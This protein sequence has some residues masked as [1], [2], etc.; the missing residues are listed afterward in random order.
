M[1]VDHADLWDDPFGRKKDGL[2]LI[3]RRANQQAGLYKRLDKYKNNPD[4]LNQ[5]LDEIGYNRKFNNTDELITFYSDRAIGKVPKAPRHPGGFIA[6]DLVEGTA[7]RLGK[8]AL[9]G[10]RFLSHD[11][12]WPELALGSAEYINKLQK[13]QRDRAGGE[14]LELMSLGLYD[15][16]ATE[17][18]VLEQ[19]KKLGYG[20]KD[21]RALENLMRYNKIGKKIRGYEKALKTM[22]EGAVDIESEMG[23]FALAEQ[24]KK[25]KQEQESVAG[26]YFGAIGDKDVN[27]G[28]EIY[29]DA[30]TALGNEE[31]NRTL[32]D[33]MTR[34]DPYA[35]G[36]G[37]WLLNNIFT[38]DARGRAR[39]QKR[40][41]A[42]SP[43][44]LREFNQQR[45]VL[46]V[47]PTHGAYDHRRFEDL[48]ESLDYMYADGGIASLKKKW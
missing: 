18:A 25:L 33:R 9:K 38:L 12:V 11:M 26:F 7:K 30:V 44:E 35:G 40:I 31:F 43:Q 28:T 22:G 2:R 41:D 42:M 24:I 21:I 19:A 3:D 10:A 46:P 36:I 48:Q 37:N 27:Y 4:L 15:S 5:K 8:G 47:G 23:N 1:E 17:E 13:G 32:E 39:E 29:S 20:E 6:R 45:G 14:T 34:R 16:G